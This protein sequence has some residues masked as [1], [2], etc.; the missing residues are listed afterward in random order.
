[1]D[2][3]QLIKKISA[4]DIDV[5]KFTSMVI[6]DP[7]TREAVVNL[8]LTHPHIMVYYHC[9]Y[10]LDQAT[11]EKPNLFYHHWD[12]FVQLLD[13]RNSYHRDIGMTLL[14]NLTQVDSQ[15]RFEF[16]FDRF[17]AHLHDAKFLT[18]INCVQNSQKVMRY[19]PYL[20]VRI[21]PLLLNTDSSPI[22]P[23]N[24]KS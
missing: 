14:S 4:V 10:I 15:S 19:K 8:V 16:L 24:K 11:L 17:F 18:A 6:E 3:N 21:L 2:I 9:Y 13:H 5:K 7:P 23:S 1:M 20:V 12:D 22:I